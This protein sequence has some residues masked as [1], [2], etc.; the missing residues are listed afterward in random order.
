[1]VAP[2]GTGTTML[3]AL[4]LVG[5]ATIPLKRT[6]LVP[7][8]DPK[9]APLIVTVL[10]TGPDTRD[11]LVM[12]GATAAVTVNVALLLATPPTVTMTL[13]VVAPLGT[14]TAILVALQLVGAATVPLN[15]T[16]LAPCVEPKFAPLIVTVVPTAPADGD[17]PLMV[18]AAAPPISAT[19]SADMGLS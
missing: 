7:C 3:L 9:F 16:L 2:L 12:L 19:T 11:R 13:P 17:T 8:V 6:R 18:G 15:R 4:Q 14:L 5:V 10:P 1:V